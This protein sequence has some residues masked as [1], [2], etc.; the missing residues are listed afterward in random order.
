MP[1][2]VEGFDLGCGGELTGVDGLIGV[3][4]VEYKVEDVGFAA[5]DTI[6]HLER[7]GLAGASEGVD[8]KVAL[9]ASGIKYSSL[10][11]GRG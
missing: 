10:F 3:A 2:S 9:S 8:L 6:D 11:L 1:T 4:F 5:E 7:G